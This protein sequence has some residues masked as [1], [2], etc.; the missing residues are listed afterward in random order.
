MLRVVARDGLELR[1]D[2]GEQRVD[3]L[4]LEHARQ[5]AR[6]ARRRDRAPRVARREVASRVAQRWNERM[7][8]S[9]CATDDRARPSPRTPR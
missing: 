3:L 7:A 9:R 2:D 8:A 5:A 4:D 1:L 6:Q